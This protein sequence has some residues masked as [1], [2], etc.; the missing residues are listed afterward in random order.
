MSTRSQIAFYEEG[1]KNLEKWQSL[2]YRHWDGYPAGML[3]DLISVLQ[4]FDNNR[5]IK[6]LEYASAWLVAKLKTDYLNVGI[7][8]NFHWD[9][10]Y[11]YGVYADGTVKIFQ[12]DWKKMEKFMND[13]SGKTKVSKS[14]KKIDEF[15]IKNQKEVDVILKKYEDTD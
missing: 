10:D 9:I 3:P 4:D 5:G 8:K 7:S 11:V 1:E 13:E 12:I 2:I 15:N 14:F 6:D